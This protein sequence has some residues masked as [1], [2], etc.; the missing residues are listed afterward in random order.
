MNKKHAYLI[1]AHNEPRLL[2]ILINLLDDE[3][4][5]IYILIDRKANL[6]LFSDISVSKS[7]LIIVDRVDIRWG[8]ISQVVAEMTLFK[9][10]FDNGPYSFY[11]LLSGTDLPIKSQ[12]YI[13]KFMDKYPNTEFVGF[14]KGNDL[15]KK[16]DHI[17]LFTKYY[18]DSNFVRKSFCTM[19]RKSF[20]FLQIIVGYKRKFDIELKKGSNWCSITNSFCAYLISK[21]DFVYKKFRFVSCP[22]EIF[23]QTILWASP[24]KDNI[25]DINDEFNSC[26]REIDW[27]RGSP[28]TWGKNEMDFKILKESNKLFARK[29]SSYNIEIVKKIQKDIE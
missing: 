27:D 19:V 1:I 18:K 4:N 10:A 22:D 5:D 20:E 17:H 12:N 3:R 15:A 21:Q 14:A 29:F 7:S 23:L 25:Y 13:H 6:L 8:D 9:T 16:T 11:H 24:F 26:L 2:K 28:Y